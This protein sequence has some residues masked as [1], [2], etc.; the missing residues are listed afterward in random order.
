MIEF[1]GHIQVTCLHQDAHSVSGGGV[2]DFMADSFDFSPVPSDDDGG[3]SYNCNK[4]FVI[5]MPGAGTLSE[6]SIPRSCIVKLF[7]NK[8]GSYLIGTSGI[9][10]RA[11]IS[12]HLNRAQLQIVCKMLTNPLG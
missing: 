7:S 6:F 12:R 2:Y 9:P 8:G 1:T 11:I 4:T 3:V 10:A 5:D